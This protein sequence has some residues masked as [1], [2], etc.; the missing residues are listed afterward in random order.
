VKNINIL[1]FIAVLFYFW[2]CE[3]KKHSSISTNN[4]SVQSEKVVNSKNINMIDKKKKVEYKFE[5]NFS[6]NFSDIDENNHTISVKDKKI[7]INNSKE[8]VILLNFFSSKD[9]A[10]KGQIPYLIDT[11]KKYNSKLITIGILLN[12]KTD[13][14]NLK[15]LLETEKFNYNIYHSIKN[16]KFAEYLTRH[17][18]LNKNFSLPMS[19]LF[20]NGKYY[21]HY[22]GAVP[23]E[24]LEYDIKNIINKEK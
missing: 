11:Q 22:E 13:K 14:H 10:C 2:G 21:V 20:K 8:E 5:K 12:S 16:N 3:D 9:P 17:F 1:L 24:M 15:T 4:V 23:I 7:T 19:I 18:S 6:F